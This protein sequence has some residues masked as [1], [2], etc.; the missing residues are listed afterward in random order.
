ML[1]RIKQKR[2]ETQN[3]NTEDNDP[4]DELSKNVEADFGDLLNPPD[5]VEDQVDD[6]YYE[7]DY[8]E[9]PS[10][11]SPPMRDDSG[12]KLRLPDQRRP[13]KKV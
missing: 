1:E 5:R 12:F 7:Y 4:F 3:I 13:P 10:I 6:Y 9:V 2:L 11:K 8:V